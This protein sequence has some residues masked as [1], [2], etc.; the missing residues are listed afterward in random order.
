M[1]LNEIHNIDNLELL[2]HLNSESIDLIYCD[3]LYNTKQTFKHKDGAVAYVDKIDNVNEF[4]DVRFEEMYRVLSNTGTII[5][6]CDYRTSPYIH[7]LLNKYFKFQ[8]KIVWK[9]NET[10]K[11]AKSKKALSKDY[12]EIFYFTKSDN[13]TVN[14]IKSPHDVVSLKEFKYFDEETDKYFKIVPLGMYSKISVDKMR[15]NGE[16]YMTKSGKEYKKYYLTDYNEKCLSN[17]WVDCKNLYNGENKEMV[18]YPTQKPKSLLERIIYMF[19][20]KG[21]VIADFFCG[22]GTSMVVAK[23]LGRQYIGCDINSRAVEI[24][25][26][27]LNK[28]DLL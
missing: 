8:D 14:K 9:K 10:G 24:T 22:S 6:Q 21:D 11:G 26:E 25:N 20:D 5:I 15:D 2:Q 7:I 18:D 4:Y 13:F 17:I 19:S 3:I 28:S 16:L 27:R 23:E 12:D 1:K